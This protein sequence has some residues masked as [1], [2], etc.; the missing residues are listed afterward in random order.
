MNSMVVISSIL[1]SCRIEL[2]MNF[3]VLANK[4][5]NHKFLKHKSRISLFKN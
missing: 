4:R 5:D 1:M 3:F 2:T